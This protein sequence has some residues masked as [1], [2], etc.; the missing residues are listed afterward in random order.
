ML[1]WAKLLLVLLEQAVQWKRRDDQA[2]KQE[3]LNQARNDPANYL[4]QFGRVP[5]AKPDKP[6][7][8][9]DSM[10]DGGTSTDKHDGQ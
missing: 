8:S 5:S 4:R 3:R 2:K 1:S 6:K 7:D 9:A 10:H